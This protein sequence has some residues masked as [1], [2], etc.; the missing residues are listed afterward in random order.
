MKR[1]LIVIGAGLLACVTGFTFALAQ[2][3]QE[4]HP[5]EPGE[6]T[7]RL[8]DFSF[9]K[10]T[11]PRYTSTSGADRYVVGY[12]VAWVGDSYPGRSQCEIDVRGPAGENFGQVVFE[13][14]SYLPLTTQDVPVSLSG[15]PHSATAVCSAAVLPSSDA[16]Y[17]LTN[18][19]VDGSGDI[20][21]LFVDVAWATSE[22]PLLQTCEALLRLPNDTLTRYPFE[23][24]APEGS[25]AG[26]VV[27]PEQL[28]DASAAS[29]NCQPFGS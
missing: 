14:G 7:Y 29:V 4:V 26:V 13:L 19:T 17:I 8:T 20:P 9:Q 12:A 3:R 6:D 22:P 1:H 2:G 10:S 16:G 21:H 24:S 28:A 25:R 5:A 27:L 18:P 15:T 11:D 23:L